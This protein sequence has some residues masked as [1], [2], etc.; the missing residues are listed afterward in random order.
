MVD[1]QQ[2]RGVRVGRALWRCAAGLRG[3]GP[4]AAPRPRRRAGRPQ[5]PHPAR[6]RGAS[7]ETRGGAGRAGAPR[8]SPIHLPGLIHCSRRPA[9]VPA[10]WGLASDPIGRS[11][12]DPFGRALTRLPCCAASRVSP[13]ASSYRSSYSFTC[14]SSYAFCSTPS[15]ANSYASP[16]A[17]PDKLV[18]DL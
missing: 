1:H 11:G 17:N 4:P 16:Y 13:C 15:S 12:G 2:S 5:L 8:M 7:Q 14:A 9:H 10:R 3:A 6:R 18:R